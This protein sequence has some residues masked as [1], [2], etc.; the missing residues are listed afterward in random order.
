[1][2]YKKGYTPKLVQLARNPACP[3]KEQKIIVDC[4]AC[5]I[6]V[7]L[8]QTKPIEFRLIILAKVVLAQN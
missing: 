6:L 8:I 3:Y 1:M 2:G 7:K 5:S 4:F